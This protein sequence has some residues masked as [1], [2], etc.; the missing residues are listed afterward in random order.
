VVVTLALVAPAAPRIQVREAEPAVH[1]DIDTA[2][3]VAVV[4]LIRRGSVSDEALDA[5]VGLPGTQRMIKKTQEF[6]PDASVERFKASLRSVAESGTSA[7][8]PFA[9]E[10]VRHQLDK[11]EALLAQIASHPDDLAAA[12]TRR[13]LAYAPKTLAMKVKVYFVVG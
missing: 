2:S 11:T 6:S 10:D 1:I 9:L 3:A 5:I 4:A 12:V 7:S 8:D 13:I